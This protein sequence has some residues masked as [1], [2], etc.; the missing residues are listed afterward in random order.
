M[1]DNNAL[2][3]AAN[4][5]CG[6]FVRFSL[7]IDTE[8]R[9]VV[10]ASFSSNGCGFMLAAAD[11]L[12]ESVSKKHV[13][14]LHGLDDAEL[15][16]IIYNSLG[17]FPSE[18]KECLAACIESLRS[19]FA[20]FRAKQIEEFQGEKA[21]ICTC[22]GVSEETIETLLSEPG[23]IATGFFSVEEITRLTNAGSGCGS[24][25]MLIQEMIDTRFDNI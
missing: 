16:Q 18:R 13:T 3:T 12:A 17:E 8:S 7:L 10:E 20:D 22:F 15:N 19:A 25:R 1:V 6:S 5:T 11:A 4:F 9:T 14:E 24:C 23:A 2:G 21:L